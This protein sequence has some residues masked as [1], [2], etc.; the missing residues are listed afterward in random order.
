MLFSDI[1]DR[2]RYFVKPDGIQVLDL[3]VSSIDYKSY[4]DINNI[5]LVND[6]YVMRPDLVAEKVYGDVT[7]WDYIL[8]YNGI[9]N[10]FSL[11]KFDLISI[12]NEDSMAKQFKKELELSEIDNIQEYEENIIEE[13]KRKTKK[14][15]NRTKFIEAIK[16]QRLDRS[17]PV[18]PNVVGEGEKNI[19]YKDNKILFGGNVTD[20]DIKTIEECDKL[21][22]RTKIKEALLSRKRNTLNTSSSQINQD[23]NVNQNTQT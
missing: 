10:P 15:Y 11:D 5:F 21:S 16:D 3:T 8:K 4:V 14:D 22:T 7:K 17:I 18:P 2:K 1:I 6:D 13:K 23:L 9:S 12:P 19:S 20:A